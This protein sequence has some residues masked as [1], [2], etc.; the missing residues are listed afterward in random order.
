MSIFCDK[1][2]YVQVVTNCTNVHLG[3]ILAGLSRRTFLDDV[4]IQDELT[5][6]NANLG[7][8]HLRYVLR[9]A[10]F[11]VRGFGFALSYDSYS[12]FLE[13]C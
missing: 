1:L 7:K 2:A 5:T 4:I 11:G 10:E 13:L 3:R 8:I 12:T 9:K 6:L